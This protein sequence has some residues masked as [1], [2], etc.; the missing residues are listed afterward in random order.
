M[1]IEAFSEAIL[2]IVVGIV[3]GSVAFSGLKYAI[4]KKYG[5]DLK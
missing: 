3:I 4:F 2:T 5:W 1:D